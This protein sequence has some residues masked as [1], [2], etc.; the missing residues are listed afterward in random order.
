MNIVVSTYLSYVIL[1]NYK[2][3]N[4]IDENINNFYV[5]FH[6]L[7]NKTYIPRCNGDDDY[8]EDQIV[9]NSYSPSKKKLVCELKID[10]LINLCNVNS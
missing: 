8:N 9:E 6:K 2:K 4:N 7:L 1:S 3:E 10:K 5:I